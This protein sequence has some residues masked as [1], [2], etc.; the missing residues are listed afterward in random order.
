MKKNMM[1]TNVNTVEFG[2]ENTMN[3][4]LNINF[5]STAALPMEKVVYG[6]LQSV[7]LETVVTKRG[8]KALLKVVIAN[9]EA[10]Y[11]V[12]IWI[13][14]EFQLNN[15]LSGIFAQAKMYGTFNA[16][17]AL[18]KIIAKKVKIGAKAYR[19]EVIDAITEEVKTFVNYTFDAR[20]F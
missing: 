16:E 14:A 7:N 1:N 17:E 12:P 9:K 10:T 11:E 20:E 13:N 2:K 8:E 4:S 5:T 3:I 15:I 6:S 19:K 18:N